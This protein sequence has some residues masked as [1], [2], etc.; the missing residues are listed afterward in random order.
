[1]ESLE[2]NLTGKTVMNK[3]GYTLGVIKGSL[4]NNHTGES[5][6]ILVKPSDQIDPN[7]YNYNEH[8]DILFPIASIVNVKDIVIIE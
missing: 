1:M 5:T 3:E 4:T 7:T 6:S 2:D 8:G